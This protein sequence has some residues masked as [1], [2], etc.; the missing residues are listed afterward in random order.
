MNIEN[1]T[2]AKVQYTSHDAAQM[3]GISEAEFRILAKRHELTAPYNDAM[4]DVIR[5][6]IAG[7]NAGVYAPQ[8]TPNQDA[9]IAP[10]TPDQTITNSTLSPAFL[11]FCDALETEIVIQLSAEMRSRMPRIKTAVVDNV[12]PN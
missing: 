1:G 2:L 6:D 7:D 9:E 3:L 8:N 10:Q 5:G 12:I 4:L 11:L